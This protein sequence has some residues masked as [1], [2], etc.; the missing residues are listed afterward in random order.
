MPFDRINYDFNEQEY[1]KG[2]F[3]LL[4][5]CGLWNEEAKNNGITLKDYKKG[6]TLFGF[7]LSPDETL[8]ENL[9]LITDRVLPVNLSIPLFME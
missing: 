5:S 1:L 6:Y 9:N 7:N 3:G 4:F 8:G 2:Y